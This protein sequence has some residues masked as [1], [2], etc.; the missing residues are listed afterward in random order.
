MLS[1]GYTAGVGFALFSIVN[2]PKED[3][4]LLVLADSTW[5]FI[6]SCLAESGRLTCVP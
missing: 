5:L 6:V 1:R 3:E 2:E 4:S